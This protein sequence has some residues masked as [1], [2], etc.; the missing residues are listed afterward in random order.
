MRFWIPT[1]LFAALAALTYIKTQPKVDSHRR[2]LLVF[3]AIIL[4]LYFLVIV[5]GPEIY[6]PS[7]CWAVG[8]LLPA[9]IIRALVFRK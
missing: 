5:V 9:V 8:V 4:L 3:D 1:I 2:S 7:L 6:M